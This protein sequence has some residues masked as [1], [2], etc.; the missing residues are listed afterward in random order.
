MLGIT[1]S[2]ATLIGTLILGFLAAWQGSKKGEH[3]RSAVPPNPTTALIGGAIVDSATLAELTNAV[4]RL[5][6]AI[7]AGI[8]D[9]H[10]R[11]VRSEQQTM[12]DLLREIVNRLDEPRPL[13]RPRG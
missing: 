9:S 1:V 10:E 8:Q 11:T 12:N 3:A 6:D 7:L 2:D 4:E 5:T 13:R